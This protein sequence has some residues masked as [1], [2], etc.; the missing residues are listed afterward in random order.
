M[1]EVQ[2]LLLAARPRITRDN[3]VSD[4]ALSDSAWSETKAIM[5]RLQHAFVRVLKR[6]K[7]VIL[8]DL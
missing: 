2:F 1:T 4:A 5:S 6:K 7:R 3:K 8:G